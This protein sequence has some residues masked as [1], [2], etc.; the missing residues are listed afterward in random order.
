MNRIDR[1]ATAPSLVPEPDDAA[2]FAR[3]E[4]Y[5]WSLRRSVEMVDPA[6]V[7]QPEPAASTSLETSRARSSAFSTR[8]AAHAAP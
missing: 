4:T 5:A 7:G 1:Y 2:F 8:M 3:V 6:R